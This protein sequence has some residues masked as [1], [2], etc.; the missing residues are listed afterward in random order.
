MMSVMMYLVVVRDEAV[1]ARAKGRFPAPLVPRIARVIDH[2][3]PC[4][5]TKELPDV[6]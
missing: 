4:I 3:T 5:L 6:K 2:Y 1:R